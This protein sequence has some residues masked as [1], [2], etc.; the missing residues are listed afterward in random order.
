MKNSLTVPLTI[1]LS[2]VL[3]SCY[4]DERLTDPTEISFIVDGETLEDEP[5]PDARLVV[6]LETEQ[7]VQVFHSERL[8]FIREGNKISTTLPLGEGNYVLTEFTI[9]DADGNMVYTMVSHPG[10][11]KQLCIGNKHMRGGHAPCHINLKKCFGLVA[12]ITGEY[13]VIF[14]LDSNIKNRRQDHDSL[15]VNWGDGIVEAYA[16]TSEVDLNHSYPGTGTYSIVVTGHLDNISRFS[17]SWGSS[18]FIHVNFKNLRML[19]TID[20]GLNIGPTIID[21]RHNHH[22]KHVA[23]AG[24]YELKTLLLPEKNSLELLI[25]NA[26]VSL[27]TKNVD[28][29]IS[30]VY[31][32]ARRNN[33]RDGTLGL[34]K[35]LWPDGDESTEMVGPPSTAAI[36]QL[37]ILREKY[38]WTVYPL[39]LEEW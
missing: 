8:A 19:T 9:M 11:M 26:N 27:D 20:W 21:L 30:N 33:Q 12:L 4:E 31:W 18:S 2:F 38:G 17:T 16:Q 39:D 28:R 3:W 5:V 37:Q 23:M 22:L 10:P 6:S 24:F 29:V 13:D 36:E 15:V 14:S 25:L 34:R 35:S 7:G 32:N 1:F